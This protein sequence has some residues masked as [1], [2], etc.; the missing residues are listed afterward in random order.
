[1]V[2]ELLLELL[3]LL[4]LVGLVVVAVVV[5]V[6]VVVGVELLD[7]ELVVAVWHSLA[8]TAPTVAAP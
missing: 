8:A 3:V 4:E 1:V 5:T 7:D 6:S 2:L